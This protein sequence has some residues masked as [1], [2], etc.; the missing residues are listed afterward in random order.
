MPTLRT[1][2]Q[3]EVLAAYG[4]PKTYLMSDGHPMASWERD[5]LSWCQ[6]PAP[7]PLAWDQSIRVGR[8]RCHRLIV[9]PLEEALAALHNVPEAWATIGDFGGCYNWRPRR[10]TRSKLSMHCWGLAVDLDVA[11]NPDHSRGKVHPSTI[12]TMAEHGFYWGGYFAGNDA[13]PMHF[14]RGLMA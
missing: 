8:I 6:L 12:Q 14:E 3:A 9:K 5:T 4:D 7:L 11:D 10:G 1:L 13:D 2:T